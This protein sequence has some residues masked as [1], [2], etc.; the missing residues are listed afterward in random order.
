MLIW[1]ARV[2]KKKT[3]AI[4]AAILVV[5]LAVVVVLGKHA[6]SADS[7]L[8]QLA[9]NEARVSYLQS[10]G[11][12]VE[13]EPVETLQFLLPE[14]LEEPYLTYNE[15]QDSQ[16]FDLSTA[17]GKQVSRF[18]Y[19]V[20]N[21]PNRPEGVQLNLYV[22]EEQPVAGD[23]LCAGADGFQDTLVYPETEAK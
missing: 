4:T 15:L 14:K 7:N 18:T 5:V 16:G 21:Y 22:C 9:D 23:V 17:C 3:A 8:P 1:T 13:P 2:S 12:E 11:W 6:D 10:M 19:T 20:T